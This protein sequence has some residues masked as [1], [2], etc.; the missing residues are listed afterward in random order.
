M[1][2][3]LEWNLLIANR[4]EFID[5]LNFHAPIRP[6]LAIPRSAHYKIGNQVSKWLSVVKECNINLST[7]EISDVLLSIKLDDDTELISFDATSLYTN[8]H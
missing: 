4:P 5:F 7:K 3:S 8:F 1:S 2:C 6:F